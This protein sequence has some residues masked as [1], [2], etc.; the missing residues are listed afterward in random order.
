[1]QI[2]AAKALCMN[3]FRKAEETV[4]WRAKK[5]FVALNLYFGFVS[6]LPAVWLASRGFG[7]E[8]RHFA[9]LMG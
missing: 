9:F 1:M 7:V 6:G 4:N 3:L 5:D 8:L 2:R